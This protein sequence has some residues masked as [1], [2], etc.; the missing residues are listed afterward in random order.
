MNPQYERILKQPVRTRILEKRTKQLNEFIK[1]FSS[2]TLISVAC[3]PDKLANPKRCFV[4]VE[5]KIERMG[6]S[7]I[8]GW[9]FNEYEDKC[10]QGEAHAIW[11]DKYK[12]KKFD[13]TPHQFQPERVLFLPDEKVALKRGYTAAPKLILSDDPRVVA[14]EIFNTE[15]EKT[16]E[17]LFSGFGKPMEIST[18]EIGRIISVSGLPQDVA[19]H[20]LGMEEARSAYYHNKYGNA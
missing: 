18:E 11:M 3:L 17:K 5:E 13:I 6:G 7:M 9:I 4:N 10:I 12:K 15:L 2:E 19:S 16:K 20:F 14:I 1:T 8:T